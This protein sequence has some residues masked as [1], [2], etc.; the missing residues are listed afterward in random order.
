MAQK[1]RPRVAKPAPIEE[2]KE[3]PVINETL[4]EEIQKEEKPPKEL[5]PADK[6]NITSALLIQ[7][8]P[9]FTPKELDITKCPIANM[10]AHIQLRLSMTEQEIA[11]IIPGY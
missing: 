2:I 1:R 8:F 7:K 9:I 4:K 10:K 5:T 3:T 6:W 11:A